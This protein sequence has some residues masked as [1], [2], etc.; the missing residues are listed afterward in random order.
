MN[1]MS[2]GFKFHNFPYGICSCKERQL[3]CANLKMS[4]CCHFNRKDQL[5]S[6][7]MKTLSLCYEFDKR[8]FPS[9][10]FRFHVTIKNVSIKL[11]DVIFS[12]FYYFWTF[13]PPKIHFF[14]IYHFVPVVYLDFYLIQSFHT[15]EVT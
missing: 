6:S 12:T 1:W 5:V 9:C 14:D 11:V 4:Q 3:F 15:A 7:K 8:N 10:Y 2:S 13:I